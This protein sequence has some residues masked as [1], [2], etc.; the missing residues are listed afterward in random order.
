MAVFDAKSQAYS[1]I[2]SF[3]PPLDADHSP[4]QCR[5]TI[6][7]TAM[8]AMLSRPK[9]TGNRAVELVYPE[10]F[11]CLLDHQQF[12]G[13]WEMRNFRLGTIMNTLAGLLAI[14]KRRRSLSEGS[15][16]AATS[17]DLRATKA[18]EFLRGQ[19]ANWDPKSDMHSGSIVLV[20]AL[21]VMLR[22]ENIHFQFRGSAQLERQIM[23]TSCKAETSSPQS[24]GFSPM[25]YYLEAHVDALEPQNSGGMKSYHGISCSPSS[26]AAFLLGSKVWD[27][28]Y[29]AYLSAAIKATDICGGVPSLFPPSS[30]EAAYV[31]LT[32]LTSLCY[33]EK[34][35]Y[36]NED[37]GGTR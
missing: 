17:L 34:N 20:Q 5:L 18:T 8:V 16:N 10:S 27:E 30:T 21:L 37:H 36:H 11:Q 24:N 1:L 6:Y 4:P 2:E 29:E 3:K 28:E 13:G 26:T 7:D 9:K 15:D 22:A 23:E 12:N 14:A 19:L 35:A 33:P 25:L 31:S 32:V